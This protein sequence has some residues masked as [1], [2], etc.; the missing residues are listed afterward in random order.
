M[1]GL[2][3]KKNVYYA[4]VQLGLVLVNLGSYDFVIYNKSRA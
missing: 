4:Q 1:I 2:F 3:N